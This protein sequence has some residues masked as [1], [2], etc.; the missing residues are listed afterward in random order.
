[1]RGLYY[2]KEGEEISMEEAM[3]NIQDPNY[4]RIALDT[5]GIHTISTVHL[6]INHWWGWK[7]LIFET[8]VFGDWTDENV[9]EELYCE[10]Y[11]TKEE[12]IAGHK[13]TL[14]AIQEWDMSSL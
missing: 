13:R 1:M 9:G 5:V 12:A 8:M 11:S 2:N 10:R 4:K 7:L 6:H 3:K 14:L